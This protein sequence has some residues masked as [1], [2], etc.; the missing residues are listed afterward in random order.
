MENNS[1]EFRKAQ[2][3]TIRCLDGNE[4]NIMDDDILKEYYEFYTTKGKKSNQMTIAEN[5]GKYLRAVENML[6]LS[7]NDKV[8]NFIYSDYNN[9]KISKELL[10][11]A[12][13]VLEKNKKVETA[14]VETRT[15]SKEE[16][17]ELEKL[18][19]GK[20]KITR[21]YEDEEFEK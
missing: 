3:T 15:L 18:M 14:K 6:K 11:K 21:I 20:H 19:E 4:I 10:K 7:S 13:A 2:K 17:R 12:L 16:A 5:E 1:K 9:K 8:L